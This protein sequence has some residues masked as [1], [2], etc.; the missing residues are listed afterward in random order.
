M[1]RSLRRGAV[2]AVL[3]LTVAPFAAACGA[4][5]DSQ[6]LQVQPNSAATSVGN[7]KVQNAFIITEPN[8]TGPAT[9]TARIFNNGSSP[10]QLTGITVEGAAQQVKL[11]GADGK[12]GS[13]TIPANGSVTLGGSGNPTAMLSS[14][15]GIVLGNFQS[16]VFNFSSTGQVTLSPQVTPATHYFQPFGPGVEVTPST[17]ASGAPSAHP[18]GSASAPASAKPGTS[19]KPGTPGESVS[20][21]AS[22]TPLR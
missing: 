11:T 7:L 14:S 9:V 5:S 6:T 20:P 3:A 19:G 15:Q 2:A 8:G 17:P 13:I 22:E 1:S 18:S 4:G 10:E 12:S 16:T 21:S